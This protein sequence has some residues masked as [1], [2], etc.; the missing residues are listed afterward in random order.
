MIDFT[1]ASDPLGHSAPI[2]Q[3]ACFP[4]L[5][6][7]L[8]IR[9][10]SAAVIAAAERSFSQWR[11][12]EPGLIEAAEPL[13]VTIVVHRLA[14]SCQQSKLKTQNSRLKTHFIQRV[15]GSC[16]IAA[17]GANL[18]TAQMDRGVALAS[19]TPDLV[20]DDLAL[21]YHIIE[22]L[23]L[24]LASWRDRTPVHAGAVVHAGRALLLVGPSAAGKST[25]CYACLRAGFQLLAEDV[26]YV[27]MRAGLRL[28]GN[29]WR[30]HLLPDAR[31][32]F[33]ELAGR[34]PEIQ[35]NG[36]RKLA[37]DVAAFGADRVRRHVE[38]AA[39]CLIER[40]SGQASAAEL[41]DPQCAANALTSLREAGFDLHQDT[42]AVAAALAER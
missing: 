27:G 41:I 1:P 4:L 26:V 8:E 12:L 40:H 15:H 39:V 42:P 18:L 17:S 13:I 24:L 36:K 3:R 35:A 38:R 21:R 6:L 29:P 9:S 11:G 23:A 7:P 34:A 16:F 25:L 31:R 28:W 32:L 5:G 37:V 30:I 22:C 19:V 10:N 20:A 33:P 2:N 14:D